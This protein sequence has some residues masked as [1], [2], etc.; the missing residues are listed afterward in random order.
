M[1]RGFSPY[2]STGSID[3]PAARSNYRKVKIEFAGMKEKTASFW[4]QMATQ[5]E[6]P[7]TENSP[8]P[9]TGPDVIKAYL[10]TLPPAPG[11]YRMISAGGE[12]LYVGKARNL[13]NRVGSYARFGGHTNRIAAMISQTASMEFITTATETEALL[14]EANLIKRLK[15][16]YNVLLRDDKSFPYIL[17]RRDH[18]FPQ[19]QKHR[20][21]RLIKGNYFGPFA[22]AG[23]VNR[24]INAL[25][26]AFLVR[27]CSDSVFETRT[28]PCLLFQIKRC[29]GPCVGHVDESQYADLIV[30][31]EDYLAGKSRKVQDDLATRM[32]AASDGMDFETAAIYRDRIRAMTVIQ[33]HQ[34]INPQGVAE[35]DVFAAHQD[36]GR[37]CVQVFFFRA[38]QNWGN[39]AYYPRADKD[40]TP[41]EILSAFIAQFYDNKPA[42]R[43]ILTSQKLAEA[44]LLGEALGL[45]AGHKVSV[46]H[47]ERGEKR[48]LVAHALTNAREA[49][50][51]RLAESASQAKLLEG[52]AQGFGME[53]VPERIEVYDN[54]HVSGTNAVGGMIVAGPEG[55]MKNQYRKFNIK[56]QDLE[57]GD[58]FAMMR[59][60]L[61][62]RFTR[63]QKEG[64][65]R[66]KGLW[67]DLV[68]VDG[69]QGQLSSAQAVFDELGVDGILLVG[70]AKGPDRDAGRE[71]FF[72]T[73]RPSF[74]MEPKS[75]VL[76]FLQRLR[77][78]AH[79]YAIGTHRA[80]RTKSAIRNPLDEIAGVGAARKRA[81][82]T[83]FGSAKAVS[84]AALQ[85]LE[86]VDGISKTIASKVYDHFQSDDK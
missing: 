19:V 8:G 28:R 81:L 5:V 70:I 2:L 27:S 6:N 20:G 69:G 41:A 60:V 45:R 38:G 84:G 85:D 62:R 23:A 71:R 65:A 40:D 22:S 12:V 13:R 25:Q 80:R 44:A 77:D 79:R 49:L 42:P 15:P 33:G 64:A 31:T 26:K 52:V 32:Q 16:R 56:D 59:E 3:K 86:T 51:R 83:H 1:V 43:L 48:E 67:P 61:R 68:L 29:V 57:P 55:L 4:A 54:S 76:Y 72:M 50:G 74:M 18:A 75:P 53:A 78:E 36:G 47:P 34:G 82:L 17:I 30:Q 39:H 24:T 21:A 14:L 11:V 58:D 66:D 46:R 63:L 73:D 9:V 35:A 10:K 7:E 37:T